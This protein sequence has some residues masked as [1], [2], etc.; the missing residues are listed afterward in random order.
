MMERRNEDEVRKSENWKK[1]TL[2][3]LLLSFLFK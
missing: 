3:M 2:L 1:N